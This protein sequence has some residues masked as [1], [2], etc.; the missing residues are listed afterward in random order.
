MVLD[1]GKKTS[2]H[3]FTH[4][5]ITI[6]IT[7]CKATSLLEINVFK[8]RPRTETKETSDINIILNPLAI[9]VPR[10]WDSSKGALWI[11]SGI[12]LCHRPFKPL[13]LLYSPLIGG[14]ILHIWRCPSTLI[15]VLLEMSP[16]RYASYAIVVNPVTRHFARSKNWDSE[17]SNETG[18]HTV[19]HTCSMSTLDMETGGSGFPWNTDE[20]WLGHPATLSLD[21]G[22][23]LWL[24]L[25]SG[26]LTDLM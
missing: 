6:K 19:A 7:Q 25:T 21:L 26:M 2:E 11:P 10:P 24:T 8:A 14:R 23:V 4:L 15:A 18:S 9:A 22:L 17:T 13:N 3:S 12:H 1:E 16:L 20:H 5:R